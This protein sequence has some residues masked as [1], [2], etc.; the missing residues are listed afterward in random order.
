MIILAIDIGNTAITCGVFINDVLSE[1]SDFKNLDQ[2]KL[3]LE[4]NLK[5]KEKIIISSVVPQKTQKIKSLIQNIKKHIQIIIID[6]E[7]SNLKLKVKEPNS[8]GADRLC[9]IKAALILHKPPCIIIDFGTAITYD[10]INNNHEFIGGVIAPGIETSSEYLISKAAL[11]SSTDLKFP[12]KAIGITTT[13]N[14]QSGIMFGAI[15]Q[16]NGMIKRIEKET[17]LKYDIILTGGIS[18]ILSLHFTQKHILDADLTLKGMFF[19]YK[20]TLSL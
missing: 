8:V 2:F 15:D 1:R 12:P 3:Y 14:I 11:L 9:N 6:A 20:S 7:L 10:V 13:E 17:R 19:I 16:V 18:K 4:N 5:Q